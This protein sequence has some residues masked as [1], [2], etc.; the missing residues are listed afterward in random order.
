M[1]KTI[2]VILLAAAV[3]FIAH[4]ALRGSINLR[5]AVT[6]NRFLMIF[7]ILTV[8]VVIAANLYVAVE[9][10]NIQAKM[11]D[12]L[13]Q[14]S[15]SETDI[16]SISIK[17]SFANIVLSYNEWIISVVYADEPESAYGF[18]WKNGRI[19]ATGVSTTLDKEDLKH[20]R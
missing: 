1:L 19:V 10:R 20:N 9:S 12:Y 8:T 17:H 2:I 14:E 16:Q 15:Y 13:R 4:S 11:W 5:E 18:T 7:C 3:S 6:K